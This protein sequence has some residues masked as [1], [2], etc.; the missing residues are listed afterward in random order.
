MSA[1][2]QSKILT[3]PGDKL[4]EILIYSDMKKVSTDCKLLGIDFVDSNLHFKHRLNTDSLTNPE[5]TFSDT[6]LDKFL[7]YIFF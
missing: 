2:Y 4:K 3:F 1:G 5:K 6:Q 7:P